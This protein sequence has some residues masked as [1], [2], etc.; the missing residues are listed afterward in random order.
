VSITTLFPNGRG[1]SGT[2][3]I[4]QERQDLEIWLDAERE[5]VA[6]GTIPSSPPPTPKPAKKKASATDDIDE[7]KVLER[8]NDF[9]EHSARSATSLGVTHSMPSGLSFD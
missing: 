6:S 2:P 4:I 5:L 9:G 7:F 8:L 1:K 3:A